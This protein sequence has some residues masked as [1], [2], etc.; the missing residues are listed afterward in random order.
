MYLQV[1]PLQYLKAFVTGEKKAFAQQQT[2][3][4]QSAV[5]TVHLLVRKQD[6]ISPVKC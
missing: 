5:N 3:K 4:N 1:Y 2:E 6:L